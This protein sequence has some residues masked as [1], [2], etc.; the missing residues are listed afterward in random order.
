M[1]WFIYILKKKKK[2]IFIHHHS[3]RNH[4]KVSRKYYTKYENSLH[5]TDM[6]PIILIF[7]YQEK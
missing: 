2:H 6:P 1:T 7:Y 3:P 4:I 5:A